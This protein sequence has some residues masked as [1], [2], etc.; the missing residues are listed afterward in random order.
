ML[1][2]IKNLKPALLI[3]VLALFS[4]LVV[5]QT[6]YEYHFDFIPPEIDISSAD[7]PYPSV[8]AG[9]Q[10]SCDGITRYWASRGSNYRCL[11]TRING[12]ENPKPTYPS[13]CDHEVGPPDFSTFFYRFGG[14]LRSRVK[15]YFIT[16][17]GPSIAKPL[18]AGGTV[19]RL[20]GT[21]TQNGSPAPGIGVSITA[22]PEAGGSATLVSGTTDAA[23]QVQIDYT[24]PQ[25][26]IGPSK[27][28]K[29]RAD[30]TNCSNSANAAV[31]VEGTPSTPS[32]PSTSSTSS[33]PEVCTAAD[34]GTQTNNPIL[35]ATGTKILV[36]NDWQDSAAH[37]L[38]LTRY[39][40]SKWTE[41]AVAGLGSAWSHS[42]AHRV[43]GLGPTPRSRTVVWGDGS[44]SRFINT[45]QQVSVDV[46]SGGMWSCAPNTFCSPN[47][48]VV[49][50]NLYPP[51]WQ[52]SGSLDT[53][54]DTL[55]GI[56]L[57]RSSDDS[58]WLFDKT[59][60]KVL[61]MQQRNG[62]TT[63][64]TYN[65]SAQLTQV[66]NAFGRSL[67]FAYNG[68]S[69][70]T[71]V[72]L[73]DAKVL[74]FAYDASARLNNVTY[75]D[76][77]YKT[78]HYEDAA[79]PQA[80]T[81]VTDER[82]TRYSTY[83]YD[84]QGR[85]VQSELAGG[86]DRV[87]VAYSNNASAVTDALNTSRNYQYLAL[88]GTASG[89][90]STQASSLGAD[91]NSIAA[92]SFDPNSLLASQ[93]DFLGFTNQYQWDTARRLKTQE[94]RAAGRPEAQ[95]VQTQWHPTL[96]LPTLVT[97]AGRT[98]A[99]T[100]DTLGNKLTETITDTSVPASAP[101]AVRTSA[102][103]YNTQ[104]LVVLETAPNGATTSY[105]YDSAGNP[106]T[107]RN[108]L[109]HI[110][111]MA[112]AGPDGQAGRVTSMTAP[113]GVVS[114]YTYDARGRLL[115]STQV[116]STATL[117]SLYT[118]TP[119]GQLA[120]A[121]LPSGHVVNYS[122]DAAQRLVGWQDNRGATGAYTL[123]PMG[124]RTTEQIKNSAGQVVWQLARS[125]NALN[126][127]ASE[128][129]G[130]A[131]GTINSNLQTS[132]G[133]NANG[134][135]TS[136]TNGLSQAT[137]Y[138]LDALRRVS[139]ITN[140][141]NATANLSYNALDAVTSASDFKGVATSTPRDALGN[142]V[143]TSSPDAGA[144]TAEY[145]ALGLPKRIVD[146]LG[147]ATSITRDALGRP[148]SIVHA[149]GR[150]TT[151]RYDLT[152]ATYNAAGFAN[153]SKGYVSEIAD[154]TDNTKY[155]RDGFGRVVKKTQQLAP[156]T[157]GSA[158]SI[159]YSY[160]TSPTGQGSGAG[161]MASIT[162][163]NGTKVSYLYSP[164]GQISQVNW[165]TNPLIT[166]I[167]YTPLGQPASWVW[168]FADTTAT[169]SLTGFKTYDSAGRVIATELGTY[170][171]DSAGRITSLS[172]QLYVPSGTSTTATT[173]NFTIDYDSLGRVSYFRHNNRGFN[174][175]FSYDA[176]GNRTNNRAGDSSG[177][178]N[179]DY[180]VDATSNRLL[181]FRQTLT[182]PDIRS[183][184]IN[185]SYTYDLNGAM[186]TDGLRRYEYDAAN[187]LANVTT[188]AGVDAPTTRYVHN[189]LGQRLF[190]TE[191][192]FAPVNSASNPADPG[193]MQTLLTF[194]SNLWGG[195]TPT[196]TPTTS[197][198]P[199]AADQL[200]F[201]YYYDEDGSL[202]YEQ[203][204]GGAQSTGS[205]HYVYLPTPAGPMPVAFYN[206]S[207]HYAVHTDH[208][209][210]P[211]RLTQSDKKIAWQWAC[212]A[213]GD[214]LPTTARN[215]FVD[216]TNSPSLGT[217]TVA[218]VTFNLRYPGQYYDKESG[219]SYNY[220]RSY[221]ADTGRYTQSDPIDLQGGWNKFAYVD[222][223]P[224]NFFD[225]DGLA[226][227]DPNPKPE[228]RFPIPGG[229]GGRSRSP[230]TFKP[231]HIPPLF[232]GTKPQQPQV[233]K[234]CES[235]SLSPVWKN[236]SPFQNNVRSNGQNGKD[237]QY[238]QW[239]H[240]HGDIEV[241]DRN[242]IHLG[243]MEP[244]TGI[245]H[246]PPV[247]GRTLGRL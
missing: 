80:V 66:T 130:A 138:G 52:A 58:L 64:Y 88:S 98:T 135:L 199:S 194:F 112:Y 24:P 152:G 137:S 154:T 70:L 104:S 197:L 169:T 211:R 12:D 124:N 226:K 55:A 208:L 224:L 115:S 144:Q 185:V 118:Y 148:T 33:T 120:S 240:T 184:A 7:I 196:G 25:S 27:T 221:S 61:S 159:S 227:K 114:S 96:R 172:Q 117:A 30:C 157:T 19:K 15:P 213:F 53:L 165:G 23:G 113:N 247:P 219:L 177:G 46:N 47:N 143:A 106:L 200:G 125:I 28:D 11:T 241:Y 94:T 190:K 142:A 181:G 161:Q 35:L 198:T 205:A 36:H 155:L 95:T 178:V 218:D 100:Y 97:E 195:S 204:T 236:F 245:M 131:A 76:T 126:R 175:L 192:Q 83:S 6:V 234:F 59:T 43:V 187:R 150:S 189:A 228:L 20:I 216:T 54:T 65:T 162:Y 146:A 77:R 102:W 141:A 40:S 174:A 93:T 18:S 17:S 103:Q 167:Q 149:D 45:A 145:D 160:A 82:G 79:W 127:V 44:V 34:P 229:G 191:P 91:G 56:Q 202:L 173:A 186:L 32:T 108:A 163:P 134:S 201:Q 206:G 109:G 231:I 74:S 89:F 67:Q 105:T 225:E 9:C 139:Q 207:R 212:S 107:S 51:V 132:Y 60:G 29:L 57:R 63:T 50:P 140:A 239:D 151:L 170:T 13:S 14:T 133:Y 2:S 71:S 232:A 246:K 244:N 235:P 111:S 166:N 72:T 188:G 203:G 41:T 31:L 243:S 233:G 1:H 183:V 16:L 168:Q 147:Q 153:A 8:A 214:E 92:Q 238:Y 78:Y 180:T 158:K 217:T 223:D 119:S 42:H 164:A 39:Y 222:A 193:V 116:A 237:R 22:Q 230:D 62:W 84:A 209:N 242:G 99:M 81:G 4:Q 49:D 69:Q 101:N 122:Y 171:Y 121:A 182:A 21:V 215:R 129:V 48:V 73:P 38:S 90:R 176:N 87:T 220:F 37:P 75:P 86:A 3:N 123:D 136:E 128:T 10:A 156:F 68:Q 210:T 85:A 110:T 26:L 179:R 5:A